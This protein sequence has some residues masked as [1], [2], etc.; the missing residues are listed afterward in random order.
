MHINY[1]DT[2]P[3]MDGQSTTTSDDIDI[4]ER[5]VPNHQDH[6]NQEDPTGSSSE[7][8]PVGR[9]V[10][11]GSSATHA[12]PMSLS[13]RLFQMARSSAQSSSV[14]GSC[15]PRSI[16]TRYHITTSTPELRR[17]QIESQAKNVRLKISKFQLGVW[18]RRTD[19]LPSQGRAFSVEYER[20]FDQSGV[21]YMHLVYEYGLIRI[22]VSDNFLSISDE[23]TLLPQIIP[24]VN[25]DI[26][27]FISVKST[28]IHNLGIGHDE[29]GQP[30][31]SSS[32]RCIL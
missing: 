2:S 27:Y 13:H 29:L 9:L 20:D 11:N 10:N 8:V 25:Q 30:C 15:A 19:L 12:L 18:Y 6:R 16:P 3:S 21:A 17:R 23:L 22:N 14:A 26:R 32:S 28:T 31:E 24:K 1:T 4:P 5:P 7:E